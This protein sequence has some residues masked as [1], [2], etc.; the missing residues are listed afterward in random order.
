M[1]SKIISLLIISAAIFCVICP[2]QADAGQSEQITIT[3]S[4]DGSYYKGEVITFS[5][6][7]TVSDYVY[8]FICGPL[9]DPNGVKPDD[10]GTAAETGNVDTFS[11]AAVADNDTWKYVLFNV[12]DFE[13]GTYTV[14]AVTEPNNIE[15]LS[16]GTYDS[17]SIAIQRPFITVQVSEPVVQ[18][19]EELVITGNA[20]WMP[21]SVAIWV[22]GFNYWNGAENGSMVTVIPEDDGSYSYVLDGNET[23]KM[24]DGKYYAI[25]QH[26]MYN[27][28]FNVITED[29]SSGNGVLVTGIRT[30]STEE[31]GPGF[32]IG[33]NYAL[34]G[35]DAAEALIEEIDSADIDDTYDK[36]EFEIKGQV[37][38]S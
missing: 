10:P 28:E 25:V 2:V 18:R 32:Y 17:V 35:A 20:S 27:D 16:K 7:D 31:D 9:I 37:E 33:G 4:G 19:G 26:P 30:E 29:D 12:T 36:C 38:N 23:A 34:R 21:H 1:N 13:P 5:G 15:D 6:E 24:E 22:L 14:F 8:L 3:A 11:R